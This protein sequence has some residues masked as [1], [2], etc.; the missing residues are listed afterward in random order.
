MK[1]QYRFDKNWL[2]SKQSTYFAHFFVFTKNLNVNAYAVL[3]SDHEI[4]D[5]STVLCLNFGKKGN[6]LIDGSQV[7]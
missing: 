3:D 6:D 2:L 5:L 1:Y 7:V 4:Y